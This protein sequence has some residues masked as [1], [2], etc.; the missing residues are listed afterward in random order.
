MEIRYRA[1]LTEVVDSVLPALP[2]AYP[3]AR[4]AL[5]FNHP[6]V[7]TCLLLALTAAYLLPITQILCPPFGDEGT[8][9]YGAQR[10]S[11]GA[12]PGRDFVEMIGPGSFY[13]LG[14]FFKLFGAGWQ[15]SRLHL[16]FTGVATVGLLYAI[17]RQVC[18][19]SEAVL[20]W[21]FVLVMGIPLWPVVSHHWDSNLF[22]ILTFWCYLKLE[23]TN[24]PAWAAAT[25]ALAGA[26]TFFMQQKGILLL[27]ALVVSA[28][29]RRLSSRAD[30]PSR[31][32][33]WSA[34]WLLGGGYAA[35]GIA[36]LGAFWQAG[37]LRGLVYA[38][39]VW[40]GLCRATTTSMWLHTQRAWRR[41]PW[42]PAYTSS[43]RDGQPW[44]S[45]A[46]AC[47]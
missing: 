45:S 1:S 38:N 39:F 13:W 16:L 27:L 9:L 47:R 42:V 20:L 46:G 5:T 18:R 33:D 37:A 11:E 43:L 12:V 21:L 44:G 19:E 3:M 10:V 17:A 35:V 6:A 15:V 22:A 30:S 26:T 25:G 34:L 23:K 40:P 31:R 7:R 32:A 28:V 24:H 8:L 41:W 2:E 14:L 4:K 29:V 36:V